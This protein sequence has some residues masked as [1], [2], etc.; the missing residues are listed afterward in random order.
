MEDNFKSS[1]NVRNFTRCDMCGV[2]IG[3]SEYRDDEGKWHTYHHLEKKLLSGRGE[4]SGEKS[5]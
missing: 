2:G 1:P 3:T 4:K 5:W